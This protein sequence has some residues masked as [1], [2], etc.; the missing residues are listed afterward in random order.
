MEMESKPDCELSPEAWD[1][2]AGVEEAKKFVQYTI[3]HP[4]VGWKSLMNKAERHSVKHYDILL[5]HSDEIYESIAYAIA[6]EDGVVTLSS[7]GE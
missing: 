3:E 5:Q 7:D 2:V 4:S 6:E 1:D